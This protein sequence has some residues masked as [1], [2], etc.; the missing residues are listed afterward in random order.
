[1]NE[2][3]L[4]TFGAD[5]ATR[6]DG[7]WTSRAVD[8]TE[9]SINNRLLE[10]VWDEAL[11]HWA[12]MDFVQ[13]DAAILHGLNGERVLLLHRPLARR[14]RHELIA[15]GLKPPG[16]A[17]D[18]FDGIDEPHGVAIPADPAR[19]AAAVS[20]RLLPRYR[21]ALERWNSTYGETPEPIAEGN[22]PSGPLRRQW[23]RLRQRWG[24]KVQPAQGNTAYRSAPPA[25]RR[26]R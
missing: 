11:A 18:S 24:R 12:L 19:A 20:R 1:M 17:E 22:D 10:A 3:D 4:T 6:L 15:V 5:L 13:R 21:V 14:G 2:A 26:A 25:L 8:T 9:R 16:A 23:A 7:D